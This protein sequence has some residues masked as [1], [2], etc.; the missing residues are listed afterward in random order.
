MVSTF[1]FPRVPD[2]NGIALSERLHN[3]LQTVTS[4]IRKS[5]LTRWII[6]FDDID[7]KGESSVG[8]GGAGSG[9]GGGWHFR[10][11]FVVEATF[12]NMMVLFL[13]I[14]FWVMNRQVHIRP[15]K[16]SVIKRKVST[17]EVDDSATSEDDEELEEADDPGTQTNLFKPTKTSQ[18]KHRKEAR[19]S[20]YMALVDIKTEAD[21]DGDDDL[22]I[23]AGGSEKDD[24]T[25][26]L[27]LVD[28][29]TIEVT[30]DDLGLDD[31]KATSDERI[32]LLNLVRK[33]TFLSYLNEEA[34]QICLK[35]AETINLNKGE[36]LFNRDGFDGSLYVVVSGYIRL[37]FHD[38]TLPETEPSDR[39][40][41]DFPEYRRVLGSTSGPGDVVSGLVALLVGL[42][43]NE[44]E[45]T[46]PMQFSNGISAVAI[47]S[48]TAQVI[49]VPS[50]CFATILRKYP[51]DIYRIAQTVLCRAQR[52]TVQMLVMTLGLRKELLI[53]SLEVGN[54]TPG[55]DETSSWQFLQAVLGNEDGDSSTNV[56]D[57]LND[58][59]LA[60]TM[61][62]GIPANDEDSRDL[63]KA[64]SL[65]SLQ[66]G[67]SLLEAGVSNSA[68][69]LL[70]RG[71]MEIGIWLPS[72]ET[73]SWTFHKHRS[74]PPGSLVGEFECFSGEA[75]MFSSVCRTKCLLLKIPKYTYD[76]LVASHPEAMI[77]SL[78]SFLRLVS[79]VVHLLNWNSEWMH[80]QAGEEIVQRGEPCN[81]MFVVLNGRLRAG[82]RKGVSSKYSSTVIGATA[83][84]GDNTG[85]EEF[86]RGKVV[87]KVGCLLRTNWS[88]DIYAI[89][90]SEIVRVPMKLL[91]VIIRTFPGAG[92]HFARSIASHVHSVAQQRRHLN[93]NKRQS[94]MMS[95]PRN[96]GLVEPSTPSFL[97]SYGLS[98]ATIAVVPLAKGVNLSK[99]CQKL[100]SAFDEIAP[101][102]LLTKGFV[103][104]ELRDNSIKHRKA[105]L[106]LKMTSV[107]AD[108]EENNRLVVY[109]A[110]PK[111]TWWTKLCIQQADCILLVVDPQ[112]APE[113]NR[114]EQSLA[115]AFESMEVR[116]DLVVVGSD[117]NQ[118][119]EDDDNSVDDEE[120]DD[121]IN[122]SDHLN[123]WS[124]QREWIAGH[125]IV[126]RPFNRHENDFRRICR[127]VSG[128][129]VGLVLGAGG[130]RGMAHLGVIRALKEAG[131]TVDLVGGTSQGMRAKALS[132]RTLDSRENFV[133]FL[134]FCM[135]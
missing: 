126:R 121:E 37:R 19:R 17:G 41:D 31:E 110:D 91:L 58:A 43:H 76:R 132:G 134:M 36:Y 70:L 115:W 68:C 62:L 64:C 28:Q 18:Q 135:S 89:R 42:V 8:G 16:G 56:D 48:P 74:L 129:S 46:T 27:S 13:L 35:N 2:E 40:E 106:D 14:F 29:D 7:D 21:D 57:G 128:R 113:E 87:G 23:A 90:K 119:G 53:D 120:D 69:Y 15:T 84:L 6:V 65:L 104:H 80:V 12:F 124:E 94:I 20:S 1:G 98:L 30:P 92:L 111:Y 101:T 63:L 25:L 33:I 108:M 83:N 38:F 127:R 24:E 102:K 133:S 32:G 95:I 22:S 123:N 116:I 117:S 96:Y 5:Q 67:D 100:V 26:E 77:R 72:T 45:S 99:F 103:K 82:S 97:P 47:S 51:A 49:R 109:Q 10:S 9:G 50:Q 107:L 88:H 4:V 55:W 125:H 39:E 105:L 130:A 86:G 66:E 93:K 52:V 61:Q 85:A 122:V 78:D 114:V 3:T 71:T 73:G 59:K 11:L 81:S 131:I 60:L 44:H 34:M 112:N 75:S 118:G 54:E 79:P